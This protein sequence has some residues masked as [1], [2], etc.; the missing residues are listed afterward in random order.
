MVC[1]KKPKFVKYALYIGNNVSKALLCWKYRMP[2]TLQH[3]DE[4]GL[5]VNVVERLKKVIG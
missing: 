3:K 5:S 1:A 2:I 4:I